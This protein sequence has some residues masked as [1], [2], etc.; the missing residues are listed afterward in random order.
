[1]LRCLLALFPGWLG[2]SIDVSFCGEESGVGRERG[3]HA[4]PHLSSKEITVD[5]IKLSGYM[6]I[7]IPS[8]TGTQHVLDTMHKRIALYP[9]HN[10]HAGSSTLYCLHVTST[11]VDLLST[12]LGSGA[13]ARKCVCT[14][15]GHTGYRCD[16]SLKCGMGWVTG[17]WEELFGWVL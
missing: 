5:P 8:C 14:G 4:A 15:K 10:I 9:R 6:F 13:T 12:P 1:M 7:G 17:V 16:A 11:Q 2:E 3:K